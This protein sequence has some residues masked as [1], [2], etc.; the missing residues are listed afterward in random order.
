MT[1][2]AG[3]PHPATR[4]PSLTPPGKSKAHDK[5]IAREKIKNNPYRHHTVERLEEELSRSMSERKSAWIKATLTPSSATN[6]IIAANRKK[7]KRLD[8]EI[9]QINE[10]LDY[11]EKW[12][13]NNTF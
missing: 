5:A 12:G 9:K 2:V 4:P 3:S 1:A 13:N 11:S 7:V 8:G 10:M 6:R